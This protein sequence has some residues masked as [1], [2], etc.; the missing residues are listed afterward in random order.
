MTFGSPPSTI[1][2]SISSVFFSTWASNSYKS[3]NSESDSMSSFWIGFLSI[4]N[5]IGELDA[6]PSVCSICSSRT[7]IILLSMIVI[8]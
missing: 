6:I 5:I 7:I 8:W 2:A 4:I 3:G 1:K